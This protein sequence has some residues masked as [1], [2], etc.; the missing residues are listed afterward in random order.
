[1]NGRDQVNAMRKIAGYQPDNLAGIRMGDQVRL[2]NI[3][4]PLQVIGLADPLLILE[5]P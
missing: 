5:S 1:M 2:P 4:A 3:D